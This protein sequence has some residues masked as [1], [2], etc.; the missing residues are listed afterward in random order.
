[1]TMSVQAF[2][3]KGWPADE[4]ATL[5]VLSVP[6]EGQEIACEAWEGRVYVVTRVQHLVPRHNDGEPQV[7]V[8]VTL[9]EPADE[10][11]A[12]PPAA[13]VADPP[14]LLSE[15]DEA[16]VLADAQRR[17][18]DLRDE[19]AN[20]RRQDLGRRADMTSRRA[21]DARGDNPTV[22]RT[23]MQRRPR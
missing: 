6:V 8:W 17:L 23:S 4:P 20:K 13:P 12:E 2:G 10:P 15:E 22:T 11:P 3:L 5:P 21:A 16:R 1:M 19:L 9:L 14:A 7:R 18:T